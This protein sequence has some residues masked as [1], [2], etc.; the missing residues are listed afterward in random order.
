M[1]EKVRE[2]YREL[3][4]AAIFCEFNQT[5][6]AKYLGT[7]QTKI[8]NIKTYILK[9]SGI[10]KENG[11]KDEEKLKEIRTDYLNKIADGLFGKIQYKDQ[12]DYIKSLNNS[13]MSLEEENTNIRKMLAERASEEKNETFDDFLTMSCYIYS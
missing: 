4:K 13:I 6:L 11:E 10:I 3:I 5:I 7:T 12:T 1:L 8:S 9:E 2:E